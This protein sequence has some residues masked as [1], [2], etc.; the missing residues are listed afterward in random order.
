MQKV[1]RVTLPRHLLFGFNQLVIKK[2]VKTLTSQTS[3]FNETKPKKIHEHGAK[4]CKGQFI[5]HIGNIWET[6]SWEEVIALLPIS[7]A[8]AKGPQ[9]S[10][11]KANV[12]IDP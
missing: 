10:S 12:T 9:V 6:K 3:A 7:F 5:S 4:K 8:K 11:S 1:A 2:F